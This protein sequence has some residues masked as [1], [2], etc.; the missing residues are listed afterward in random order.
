MMCLYHECDAYVTEPDGNIQGNN[1]V[2][3]DREDWRLNAFSRMVDVLR[4]AKELLKSNV[5]D[6]DMFRRLEHQTNELLLRIVQ[7]SLVSS[8]TAYSGGYSSVEYTC[9]TVC[10]VQCIQ[11][12]LCIQCIEYLLYICSTAYTVYTM[13]TVY[14][15]STGYS[16][17]SVGNLTYCIKFENGVEKVYYQQVQLFA[18]EMTNWLKAVRWRHGCPAE[19]LVELSAPVRESLQQLADEQSDRWGTS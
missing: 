3:S 1:S 11:C 18:Q 5:T 12:I 6:S 17:Y 8:G 10:I 14:T 4:V 16:Y 7:A 19:F 15:I 2:C 9:S 13:H